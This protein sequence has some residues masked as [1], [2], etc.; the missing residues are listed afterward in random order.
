MAELYSRISLKR[1]AEL[2]GLEQ[3]AAEL[4][5]TGLINAQTVAAKIDR[6]DGIVTF[7]KNDVKNGDEHA[8]LNQWSS[9]LDSLLT[10]M[11]KTNHMIAKEEMTQNLIRSKN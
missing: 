9:Q 1:M 4:T 6:L 3:D 11:V 10:L 5:L 2:L 7:T 8:L